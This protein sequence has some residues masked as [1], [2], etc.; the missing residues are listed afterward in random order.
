MTAKTKKYMVGVFV[1]ILLFCGFYVGSITFPHKEISNKINVGN[2]STSAQKKRK[3]VD[4]DT[5]YREIYGYDIDSLV[6]NKSLLCKDY[7][8][9]KDKKDST[10]VINNCRVYPMFIK[11]ER[12]IKKFIPLIKLYQFPE[13]SKIIEFKELN[14][15]GVFDRAIV[16]WI[17]NPRVSI[18][19]ESDYDCAL[20]MIGH[21][22]YNGLIKF[23]LVDT[24]LK[25]I[26]NTVDF[27]FDEL[28]SDP[29]GKIAHVKYETMAIPFVSPTI[30]SRSALQS[31]VEYKVNGGNKSEE[32]FTEILDIHDY[33]GDGKKLEFALFEPGGGG[34]M[35]TESTLIGY[36]LKQDKLLWY[37][38]NIKCMEKDNKNNIVTEQLKYYWLGYTFTYKFANKKLV[39]EIDFRGRGGSL[40][41]Y[42]LVYD[43]INECFTGSVDYAQTEYTEKEKKEF[44]IE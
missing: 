3:S 4:F 1:G 17:Q 13:N 41:K 16:Y 26:I 44:G 21:G 20:S 33:N 15:S 32:G 37:P 9:L 22:Q 29:D 24:K 11:K 19:C 12:M 28:Y 39:Y 2:D 42:N 40:Q 18:Q 34:C 31:R 7:V 38:I 27:F 5:I 6:S 14:S 35:G 25:R 43:D 23:S 36:S 8:Y 30:N 10:R